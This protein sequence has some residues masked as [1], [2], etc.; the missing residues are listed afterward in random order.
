MQAYRNVPHIRMEDLHLLIG[1]RAQLN[2]WQG[3]LL[4]G[5]PFYK[6]EGA[7]GFL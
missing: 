1:V 5:A 3:R 6:Q 4:A 2:D 7:V